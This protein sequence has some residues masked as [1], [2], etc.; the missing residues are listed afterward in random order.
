MNREFE[1]DCIF[2]S[3]EIRDFILTLSDHEVL[4]FPNEEIE[5]ILNS[6]FYSYDSFTFRQVNTY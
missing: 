5:I 2:H 1:V 3:G 4:T 6:Y